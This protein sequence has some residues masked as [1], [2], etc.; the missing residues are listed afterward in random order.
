MY[1]KVMKLLEGFLDSNI[2]ERLAELLL[3]IGNELL[4]QTVFDAALKW[5][6]RSFEV[7]NKVDSICLTEN[8]TELRL[9]VMHSLGMKLH[10]PPHWNWAHSA[11]HL[12]T[13]EEKTFSESMH[14]KLW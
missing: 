3:D 6:R 13:S 9:N 7:L 4:L 1:T 10:L 11:S 14:Q 12:L 8:G 2:S 5:L